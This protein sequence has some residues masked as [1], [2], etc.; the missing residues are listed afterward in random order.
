MNEVCTFV[1]I[2][3][4]IEPIFQF[5]VFYLLIMLYCYYISPFNSVFGLFES[6]KTDIHTRISKIYLSTHAPLHVENVNQ[7]QTKSGQE[8]ILMHTFP[9]LNTVGCMDNDKKK[10]SMDVLAQDTRSL[11][12]CK[13]FIVSEMGLVLHLMMKRT[14]SSIEFPYLCVFYI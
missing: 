5:F 9:C 1:P 13:T 3:T 2:C 10:F 8:Y 7:I 4:K 6:R 12:Y 11:C 14:M